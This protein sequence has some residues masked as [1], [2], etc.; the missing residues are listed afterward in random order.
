MSNLVYERMRDTLEQLHLMRALESVDGLLDRAGAG[1]LTT[2]D[3]LDQLFG[4]ELGARRE[5]S[6]AMRLKLAGLPRRQDDRSVRLCLSALA[7]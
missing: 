3:L 1:E 7:R 5:R 4:A 2:L 6:I